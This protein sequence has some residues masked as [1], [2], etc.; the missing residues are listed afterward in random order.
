[1]LPPITRARHDESL[2]LSF[3]QLRLWLLAQTE[4]A[5]QTYHVPFG[6]L[7]KGD[8]DAPALRRALDRVVARHEALRTSFICADGEPV[9]RISANNAGFDLREHDLR[10]HADREGE[11]R[12]LAVEEAEAAFDLQKSPLV[13]G[14]LIRLADKEHVLL[15]TLHHIVSD[16]LS[17]GVLTRELSALYTAF[18]KGQA[19][20]LSPLAVQYPDYAV[21]QRRWLS[22]ERQTAQG[23]YWRSVLKEAPPVLGLPTDRS[24]PTQQNY[25]GAFVALELDERLTLALG[26]LSRRHGTTLFTSLLAGWAA[27]LSRLTGQDD[28][29]IGTAVANRPAETA[30]L[31]GLFVN[32]LALRL[33]LSGGPAVA[34]LLEQAKARVLEAQYHE[35]LPFEQ[36]VEII[37][38]PRCL[39]YQPVFQVM[40]AWE[41]NELVAPYLPG[42]VAAPIELPCSTAKFDLTL[43]L[44]EAHGRIIGGL[45][46][47]T[48]LFDRTT[49]ERH[50]GY[51]RRL[52]E[53]MAADDAQAVDRI[54]LLSETERHQLLVGW[55]A[56][57]ANYPR[58]KCVH[59]LFEAQAART[60]QAIAVVYEDKHLTYEWLNAKANRLAHH[61]QILGVRPDDRVALCIEPS[62]EMVVGLLAIL[63]AGGAYVPLGP[64]YPAERLSYML[65]DCAPS[66]VLSNCPARAALDS[67]LA[68]LAERPPV[69]DLERDAAAWVYQ[70]AANPTPPSFG[71]TPRHLAYVIYTSGSTGQPKG[72]MVEHRGLCN[73]LCWA[74]ESYAPN[75]NSIVSSSLSF[76][77][78]ITSLYLPL[79]VGG[80]A[81]LLPDRTQ[82]HS[83]NQLAVEVLDCGLVKI[84]PSHL[85]LLGQCVL[86]RRRSTS[87]EIVVVGGEAL[88]PSTVQRWRGIQ[89]NIRLVNEYGPTETVVG[90]IFHDI[91]DD[92]E[93]SQ[94][95]PVGRPIANTRIYL[96]D[97]HHQPVP[98]GVVAEI[99]IGGAGVARGYLNRPEL[100]AERFIAS[101][102]IEGDRLYKTGDLGRYRADG[103]IEFL[104]R[105]DFQVKIRGHRIELGEIE[106]RLA[107]HPGVREAVALARDDTL[108]DKRLV[109]YYTV[110]AD[111]EAPRAATLRAHL[112][113][114]LPAYML[115]AAYV[116][117]EGLPLTA[118]GKLDRRALPL[119]EADAYTAGRDAPPQGESEQTLARIF[120]EALGIE[121]IG[122][123]D[124]FFELG[125]D[126][127]LGVQCMLKIEEA[128]DRRLP[129]GA[130]F[131]TPTIAGLVRS[132]NQGRADRS[133]SVVP[134]HT[135]GDGATIFMVHWIMRDLGR[136]LGRRHPV[137]GL[138]FGLAAAGSAAELALPDRIETIASHYIDAMRSVQPYGPYHL[139][140]HSRGGLIAFEMAQQLIARGETV[141]FLGLLDTHVP[142]PARR[143]RRLPLVQVCRNLLGIRPR[144][145]LDGVARRIVHK[146]ES[147]PLARRAAIRFMPPPA[148]LKLQL[149]GVNRIR[150][151]PTPYRG[152]VHLFQAATPVRSIGTEPPPPPEV[153]WRELVRG[154]LDVHSIPGKHM[155]VVMD[156][157]AL[158]T[159]EAI[160]GVLNSSEC[161]LA[162]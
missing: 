155:N 53:A 119:P 41:Q 145:L 128:F 32:N 139:I 14:R 124:D 131:L 38:P 9:Q 61:L 74:T 110:A 132:L 76:D 87:I 100:T 140:G 26:A 22:R 156:P 89:P 162:S 106:A 127:L 15:A 102:F 133:I 135:D 18:R 40:F 82:I 158:F 134:L 161:R 56:T 126:S 98:T 30:P 60:P 153:R 146:I 88:S 20:P 101:P 1:M 78:T 160:E 33:D 10:R 150:Y 50:A 96:L 92:F 138:C 109:A 154:G 111:A 49:V 19:D 17:I 73:Y 123:H 36:V 29:V 103:N 117:L 39:A 66:V 104:G 115:P 44:K 86:S 75:K 94:A 2:P 43:K 91:P 16:S 79:L 136:H 105:N 23:D 64:D 120:A 63:K 5:R 42:L 21:W 85:D 80:T 31:I 143:P 25:A 147:I 95:I 8:L 72:V 68:L 148:A 122:R 45:E 149:E 157:F 62:L 37:N 113:S 13:R 141:A 97:G 6:L 7:L 159:A 55:N 71:L 46:Y 118:N 116:L 83:L 129:L 70:P 125:G 112:A 84:T 57:E 11:L 107:Q 35:D 51:L 34:D 54:P 59:E 108:G 24:R 3:A 93:P 27:L 65:S 137:Y 142:D 12:R 114:A 28:V 99:Y 121:R 58:D 52:L 144:A 90:C 130:L 152:R 4:R 67:A 151:E 77:A 81:R 47:A 69:L 48:A